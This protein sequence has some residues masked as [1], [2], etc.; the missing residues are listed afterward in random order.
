MSKVRYYVII[1][2]PMIFIGNFC[3]LSIEDGTYRYVF[4]DFRILSIKYFTVILR[5]FLDVDDISSV[6]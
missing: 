3:Y 4:E 6:C 5:K 2:L 1:S